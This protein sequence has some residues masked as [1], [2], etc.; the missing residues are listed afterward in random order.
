MTLPAWP[1]Q[2]YPACPRWDP[3][4]Q[5][6]RYALEAA[7]E[8]EP[9]ALSALLPAIGATATDGHTLGNTQ[10]SGTPLV[11]RGFSSYTWT[12]QLTQPLL[13]AQGK[14]VW[15]ESKAI[16]EQ[17]TAQ[18]QL[19]EQDLILRVSQ[20]YFD[21]QVAKEALSAADAQLKSTEEQLAVA[22]RGYDD[23]RVQT[24]PTAGNGLDAINA[25]DHRLLE[26]PDRCRRL[27]HGTARIHCPDFG[28]S[29]VFIRHGAHDAIFSD[30]GRS[31]DNQGYPVRGNDRRAA[32]LEFG[33]WPIHVGKITGSAGAV[34]LE[35][36]QLLLV[37]QK[38]P[39]QNQG[40]H[41]RHREH[42][43]GP[44]LMFVH[45]HCGMYFLAQ[46][47][48]LPFPPEL[49]AVLS[50]VVGQGDF[51]RGAQ[52]QIAGL[53][54]GPHS[55]GLVDVAGSAT[56]VAGADQQP[57][58]AVPLD[59]PEHLH[60]RFMSQL[61]ASEELL[62]VQPGPALV[63]LVMATR[64]HHDQVFGIVHQDLGSHHIAARTF[65][66]RRDVMRQFAEGPRTKIVRV[67]MENLAAA[68]R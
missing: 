55:C 57:R 59:L 10:Y 23:V 16:A 54:C 18:F 63:D 38:V 65:L 64:A 36:F 30:C 41:L 58:P 12:V 8:K 2:E 4:F 15:D 34:V 14:A 21:I 27:H 1:W 24:N 56:D 39:E 13:S 28:D 11:Q 48:G 60:S 61:P 32:D 19:A 9:Q 37:T 68:G 42:R 5:S 66:T 26:G 20:A 17:A 44:L 53:H 31:R 40:R 25:F 51:E 52:R 45:A 6:A 22:Q 29:Q 7:K 33:G 67:A 47:I 46:R 35:Q 3:S 50:V 49:G 43:Q 62:R